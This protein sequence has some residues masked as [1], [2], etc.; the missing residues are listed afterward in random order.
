MINWPWN[1][2]PAPGVV[3]DALLAGQAALHNAYLAGF[4]DGLLLAAAIFS[5]LLALLRR[6]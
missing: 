3:D 5:I 4:K 2:L 6:E 1:P